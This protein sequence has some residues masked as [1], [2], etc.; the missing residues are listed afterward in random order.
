MH[1]GLIFDLIPHQPDR[2]QG[3]APETLDDLM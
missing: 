2:A 3:D 1:V